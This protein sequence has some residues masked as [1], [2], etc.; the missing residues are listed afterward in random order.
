MPLFHFTLES[1]DHAFV[2]GSLELPSTRSLVQI[3]IRIVIRVLANISIL[4]GEN[5]TILV[6]AAD[7]SGRT[8]YE[9]NVLTRSIGQS[10][11]L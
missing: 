6:R 7:E 2:L 1:D 11:H 4:D 8:K 5:G 3:G 10:Y 9:F